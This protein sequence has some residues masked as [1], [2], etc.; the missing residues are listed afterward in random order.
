MT[1]FAAFRNLMNK[2]PFF[3]LISGIGLTEFPT[4]VPSFATELRLSNNQITVIQ[5]ISKQNSLDKLEKL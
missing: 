3:F 1:I 5:V 4:E 2:V